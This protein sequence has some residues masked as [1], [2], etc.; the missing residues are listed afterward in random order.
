M[1]HTISR[2]GKWGSDL[3]SISRKFPSRFSRH[4]QAGTVGRI[5]NPWPFSTF[6]HWMSWDTAG[7]RPEEQR[8]CGVFR[9]ANHR[10]E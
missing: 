9:A 4:D 7:R 6:R 3:Q 5:W 1:N 10:E 2:G 8:E